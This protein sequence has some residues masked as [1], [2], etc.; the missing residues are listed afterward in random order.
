[1]KRRFLAPW[2]REPATAGVPDN[3]PHAGPVFAD[4]IEKEL[5]AER[6]RRVVLDA[7]GVG[8]LT[9]S[10]T[11]VTIIFG[12]GALV[13][14]LDAF[15]PNALAVWLLGLALI[16]FVFA[17]LLG[18]LANRLV[19]YQLVDPEQLRAWREHD[20]KWNDDADK[21]RRVVAGANIITIETLRNGNGRKAKLLERALWA[22]LCAIGLLAAA[23]G[24][25]LVNA[26]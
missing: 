6:E 20:K 17:A 13:T 7:R 12:L 26:L 2:R 22:Q 18:L 24:V 8:V 15:E 14:G 3:P 5:R 25:T 16:A 9:T 4:F 10:G 11:L 1:M 21:A 23:I 19:V